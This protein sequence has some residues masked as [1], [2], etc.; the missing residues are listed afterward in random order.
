MSVQ[1]YP[2]CAKLEQE[3]REH[4]WRVS[5]SQERACMY[6][7]VR[8]IS[9]PDQIQTGVGRSVSAAGIRLP[10][11]SERAFMHSTDISPAL[12]YSQVGACVHF[13]VTPYFLCLIASLSFFFT[14]SFIFFLSL[15]LPLRYC[16]TSCQQRDWAAHKPGCRE[17]QRQQPSMRNSPER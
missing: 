4:L 5:D 17:K 12:N 13:L 8:P 16:G 2:P 7:Y 3:L 6:S 11:N 10:G 15:S 9:A 1:Q 14:V